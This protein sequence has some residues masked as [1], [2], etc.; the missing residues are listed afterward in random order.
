MLFVPSFE[1]N[2]ADSEPYMARAKAHHYTL[3]PSNA[4]RLIG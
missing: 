4:F 1:P 3:E 2:H